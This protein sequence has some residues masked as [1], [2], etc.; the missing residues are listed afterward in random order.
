MCLGYLE[1]FPNYMM[2]GACFQD[3][4]EHLTDL[5]SD[6]SQGTIPPAQPSIQNNEVSVWAK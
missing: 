2:Q 1:E 5:Y 4:Q 6:L 3:L